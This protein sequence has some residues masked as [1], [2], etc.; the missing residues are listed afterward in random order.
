MDVD[1]PDSISSATCRPSGAARVAGEAPRGDLPAAVVSHKMS[2][3]PEWWCGPLSLVV[4]ARAPITVVVR[5]PTTD[6][7]GT[8]TYHSGGVGNYVLE[9]WCGHLSLMVRAHGFISDG[10]GNYV[11]EWCG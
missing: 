11:S 1:I 5:A 8:C 2:E 9:W 7:F 6:G 4:W 10:V 3:E